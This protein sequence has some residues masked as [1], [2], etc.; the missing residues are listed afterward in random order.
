MTVLLGLVAILSL[1]FV[2]VL[3]VLINRAKVVG[4]SI[5]T[6]TLLED[7]RRHACILTIF[8]WRERLNIRQILLRKTALL[9]LL[10]THHLTI[11]HL[12]ILLRCLNRHEHHRLRLRRHHRCHG[13]HLHWL[14]GDVVS[15]HLLLLSVW[16][17]VG[18]VLHQIVLH[19]ERL[20]ER[21]DTRPSWWPHLD[22][23][24]LLH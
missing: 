12:D 11:E 17:Y 14:N 23:S 24:H 16:W 4:L 20:L 10:L 22:T 18:H 3:H 19:R 9:A 8:R 2:D 1:V 5:V 7:A 21:L 15:I 13:C 6:I